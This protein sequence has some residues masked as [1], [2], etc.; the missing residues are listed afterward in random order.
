MYVWLRYLVPVA[1]ITTSVVLL[2]VAYLTR[3]ES[4]V[5]VGYGSLITIAVLTAVYMVIN[6]CRHSRIARS[7]ATSEHTMTH[8]VSTDDGSTPTAAAS[9]SIV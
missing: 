7:D 1:W 6:L 5:Y 2:I 3:V 8:H 4:L 9:P